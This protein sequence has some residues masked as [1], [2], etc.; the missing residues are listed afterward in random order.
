MG[1]RRCR[2]MPSS[3][4]R[5]WRYHAAEHRLEIVF[6]SGKHYSYHGVPPAVAEEIASAASK[7]SYFNRSIRDRFAFTQH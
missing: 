7:G 5:S 4:I 3:V 6:V 2:P 1:A